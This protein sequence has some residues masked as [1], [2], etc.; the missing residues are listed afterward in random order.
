LN[1]S[2]NLGSDDLRQGRLHESQRANVLG[3]GVH[4]VNLNRSVEIIEAA[5]EANLKG[6]VCV[7]GVHGVMEAQ[8]NRPLRT[9]LDEA[10]LVVPD[11]V[12]TVW[13]GRLQGHGQMDRVFGPD[14][15]KEIC[16]RSAASGRTHFLYGGVPGVV[17]QLKQNLESWFPGIRIIGTYTPPFRPLSPAER[18]ELES[19]LLQAAPDY[20][21]VGLSTPKQEQFMAESLDSLNCKVMLGVGAAFDFHT[22]RVQD[23]PDWIKKS[24]LQWLHRLCQEPSRL[25]K[26]YL[27]SNSGF[28][29]RIAFQLAGAKRYQ[30]S[31]QDVALSPSSPRTAER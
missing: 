7:T 15:M 4:A 3:I 8:R 5:V 11:G 24:G 19:Q 1:T 14:L 9:A 17:E 10:M 16:R 26:R 13:V 27:V 22:G 2:R 31:G 28:L 12:P 21:W 23:A 29:I 25:W 18:A 20:F 6:Y 30:L